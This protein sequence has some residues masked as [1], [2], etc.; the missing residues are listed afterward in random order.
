MGSIL[1]T[2]NQGNRYSKAN[3]RKSLESLK[4]KEFNRIQTKME[5]TD[6][7]YGTLPSKHYQKTLD[8]GTHQMGDVYKYNKRK[9]DNPGKVIVESSFTGTGYRQHLDSQKTRGNPAWEKE[10]ATHNK[11]MDHL[12][13]K[14]AGWNQEQKARS[15]K[16]KN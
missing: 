7:V 1:T 2:P 5:S 15:K 3:P 16:P 9:T 8:W 10:S 4:E 11:H 6:H 14:D 13:A 12:N